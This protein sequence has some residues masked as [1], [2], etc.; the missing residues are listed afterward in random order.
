MEKQYPLL[1]DRIQ[2]TLIDAVCMIIFMYGASSLLDRFSNPPD[3]VRIALFVGILAVYEPLATALG[4]TIGNRM[5]Q[6][7]VRRYSNPERPINFFQALLRYAL[8][9][10][11]GWLSFVT[12]HSNKEK[13]AIHDLASG[14]IMVR[15]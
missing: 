7:S 5:K 3:G 11:L 14:S 8:K 1:I 4:G 12:I 9:C 2:S 15:R 6:I 13:R 10:G